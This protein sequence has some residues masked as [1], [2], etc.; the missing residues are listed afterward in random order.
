MA[1]CAYQLH[2]GCTRAVMPQDKKAKS[3]LVFKVIRTILATD[4]LGAWAPRGGGEGGRLPGLRQG[5]MPVTYS[6]A[7]GVR[8]CRVVGGGLR[9]RDRTVT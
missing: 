9:E 5:V 6:Q 8:T 4:W 2:G 3:S 1:S 7:L